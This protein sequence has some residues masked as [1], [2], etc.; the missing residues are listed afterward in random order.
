MSTQLSERPPDTAAPAA[1]P[2][3]GTGTGATGPSWGAPPPPAGDT[4]A[5]PGGGSRRWSRRLAAGLL[6][7]GLAVSSGTAGAYVAD[8]LEGRAA[9]SASPT[10]STA[11]AGSATSGSLASVAAAVAPSVVSVVVQTAG[12]QAE[13]SGVILRSDGVILTN[14]HVVATAGAGGSITVQLSDGSKA[15]AS[16]VGTDPVRDLAVIKAQGVSGL[17]PA[18]LGQSGSLEVGDTVLA[19][20]SPLGLDGSVTAGIVSALHR[21]ITVSGDGQAS[22]TIDDAIHTDAAINP[23]NSGGPLVNSAGQ[24]VGITTANASVDGQPSGSIGVG[25]AIPIGQ[26]RQVISRFV[27]GV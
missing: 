9:V 15:T 12:R 20:G 4:P 13:G 24:V 7:L 3:W 19:I 16:V 25:F 6:A 22:E 14:D 5:H 11:S 2:H 23:G 1:E 17:K 10:V 21:T 18:T 8:R 26:A 27:T